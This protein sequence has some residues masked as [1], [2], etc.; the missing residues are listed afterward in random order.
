MYYSIKVRGHLDG[1]WSEWFGGMTINNLDNG[2]ALMSGYV[3]DQ[4]ALHGL[5]IKV[6][7]LGLPLIALDPLEPEYRIH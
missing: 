5:I 3:P 1:S 2:D 7:D 6:R 4:A